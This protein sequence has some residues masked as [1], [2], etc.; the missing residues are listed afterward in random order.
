[1]GYDIHITRGEFWA[2]LSP[3]EEIS[4]QEWLDYVARDP[5]MRL[6]GFADAKLQGGGVLRIEDP[7]VAVWT[8]YSKNGIDGTQ[9]WM[10]WWGGNVNFKNPDEEILGKMLDVA[11]ALNARVQG[12]DLEFYPLP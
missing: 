1:M 8:T 4:L 6:D 9:A 7:S 11:K 3:G 10:H 12:D 2:M 5:E